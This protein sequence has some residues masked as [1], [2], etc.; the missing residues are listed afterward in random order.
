MKTFLQ[1]TNLKG[2]KIYIRIVVVYL[3]TGQILQ[4]NS[5]DRKTL[6]Q[7]CQTLSLTV[8]MISTIY[9]KLQGFI[10]SKGIAS[11]VEVVELQCISDDI[12]W[13]W[14]NDF[15]HFN[16]LT[17]SIIRSV[18]VTIYKKKVKPEPSGRRNR[19]TFTILTN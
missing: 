5:R 4:L 14:K 18:G 16:F 15:D 8:H 17:K 7:Q 11:L 10:S 2:I 1:D 12:K 19:R 3:I 9:I 13:K 6:S